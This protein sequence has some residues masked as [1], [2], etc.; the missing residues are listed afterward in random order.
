MLRSLKK[1][2]AGSK[3]RDVTKKQ[4]KLCALA[5]VK[6]VGRLCIG[7][8]D[9]HG[10]LLAGKRSPRRWKMCSSKF[11]AYRPMDRPKGSSSAE[12]GSLD[13]GTSQYPM[14]TGERRVQMIIAVNGVDPSAG[15]DLAVC[16]FGSEVDC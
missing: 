15:L 1:S 5:K 11:V 13:L 3:V 14:D 16:I 12:P 8:N 7:L 2:D 10:K 6:E 4:S 9:R